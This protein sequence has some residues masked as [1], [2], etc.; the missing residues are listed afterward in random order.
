MRIRRPLVLSLTILSTVLISLSQKLEEG[1]SAV[2][3]VLSFM[4]EAY[5]DHDYHDTGGWA[6]Q[7]GRSYINYKPFKGEL[8]EFTM[9]D[10]C[11]PVAGK[12]TS[13]YGYRARFGRF[14]YGVDVALN[15]GDTVRCVLPGV[16]T[17]TGYD[18]GG[19][20]RFVIVVH[21]GEI[22]TLYGHLGKDL[23]SPGQKVGSGEALGIGGST[24]NST[25]PHLHFETRYRGQPV[26]P[27]SWF[28]LSP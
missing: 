9:A 1:D 27:L 3:D 21:S 22:E 2:M 18:T 17:K 28:S 19:Y 8:P 24:G 23:V 5:S 7:A 4:T 11:Q 16:V 6:K 20:G 26:D 13:G 10:F 14:H 15:T 25:G 12:L